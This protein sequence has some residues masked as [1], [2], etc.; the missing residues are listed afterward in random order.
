MRAVS[1][2]IKSIKQPIQFLNSQ[3]DGFVDFIR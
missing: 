2:E 3:Q 1:P